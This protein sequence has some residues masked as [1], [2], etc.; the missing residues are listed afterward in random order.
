MVTRKTLT[1]SRFIPGASQAVQQQPPQG[2]V[3]NPPAYRPPPSPSGRTHKRQRVADLTSTS[4]GDA[5]V[6]TTH[7]PSKGVTIQEPPAQVGTNVASSS[8]PVQL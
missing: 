7:Q 8:R 5:Q 6:Q 2:C 4:P 1:V 3:P